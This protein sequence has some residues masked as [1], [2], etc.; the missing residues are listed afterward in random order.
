MGLWQLNNRKSETVVLTSSQKPVSTTTSRIKLLRLKGWPCSKLTECRT[1]VGRGEA[2][3]NT[4]EVDGQLQE[5]HLRITSLVYA[6]LC[7]YVCTQLYITIFISICRPVFCNYIWI[8]ALLTCS[9]SYIF[10]LFYVLS[11]ENVRD[12]MLDLYFLIYVLAGGVSFLCITLIKTIQFLYCWN[13]LFLPY[14][15]AKNPSRNCYF[16]VWFLFF[17][18]TVVDI[19]VMCDIILL[20]AIKRL[21]ADLSTHCNVPSIKARR[22]GGQVCE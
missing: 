2:D 5:M 9:S 22:L 12:M 11:L 8:I 7:L 17:S 15:E 3:S 10:L 4:V 19:I 16:S 20:C 1:A 14:N 18:P 13:T 21:W 6:R